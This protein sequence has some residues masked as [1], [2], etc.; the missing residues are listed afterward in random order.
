MIQ[1]CISFGRKHLSQEKKYARYK[2][3]Y[4]ASC[5]AWLLDIHEP[6]NY[7]TKHSSHIRSAAFMLASHKPMSGP[8]TCAGLFFALAYRNTATS[9]YSMKVVIHRSI[10]T[11]LWFISDH[12]VLKR[13]LLGGKYCAQCV[14]V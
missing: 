10:C 4:L 13:V 5:T 8:L 3:V 2:E 12:Q 1:K 11:V 7:G 14:Q 9:D 6:M